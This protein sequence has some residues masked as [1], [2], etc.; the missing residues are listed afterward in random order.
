MIRA[1]ARAHLGNVSG[2]Q[3]DLNKIRRR[4]GLSDTPADTQSELLAAILKERQVE[5]FTELGHRW[6]D[7]KRFGLANEV[8]GAH[9]TAWNS[10][11][12]LWPLPQSELLLN[13]NLL[14][15]NPGY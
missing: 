15:Q 1:E 14:P 5:L 13:E 11:D 3:T 7:L 9:K 2:A 4:A 10:T 8:L 6:F 12:I